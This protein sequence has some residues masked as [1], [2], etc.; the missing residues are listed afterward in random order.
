MK[1]RLKSISIDEL[2]RGR[3]AG[4]KFKAMRRG[5]G[6]Q[7]LRSEEGSERTRFITFI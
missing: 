2:Q 3:L 6:F 7:R 5:G 4:S 1:G